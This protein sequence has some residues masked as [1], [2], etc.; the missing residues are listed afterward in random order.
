LF[1]KGEYDFAGTNLLQR[2][3]EQGMQLGF[4]KSYAHTPPANTIF[5]HRKLG[6]LFLLAIKLKAKVD[7]RSLFAPY[8]DK[9][10]HCKP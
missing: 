2:L 3:R 10:I 5:L 7:M 9:T 8:L 1:T 4:D 6:G